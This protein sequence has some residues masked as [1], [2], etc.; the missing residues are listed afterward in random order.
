[1][2]SVCCANR[3]CQASNDLADMQCEA[4]QTPL[5]KR[6][7]WAVG[8]WINA[9]QPGE[10]LF[11]RYVLVESP[12]VLDM[13]PGL[14]V[15]G[16][17][18]VP[19]YIQPYQKLFPFRLNVPEVYDY[20]PS[21]DTELDL[22]VWLLHYG[23]I[24]LD[25]EGMPMYDHLLPSLSDRWEQVSPLQ[26][27]T[28]L[29]QIA[30]LWQPLL[31]YGV[32]SSLLNRD[33]LRVNGA[34]VHLQQ[35][36][37][38]DPQSY[39][40]SC[41][42]PVW[43]PLL[44]NAHPA[45]AEFCQV[46]WQRLKTGKIPHAE[47]LLTVL[48]TGIYAIAKQ[49]DITYQIFAATETV[50][51]RGQNEDACF[52]IGETAVTGQRLSNTLT[53]VCD[54]LGGQD[55]GEIASQ[56]VIE[57]LPTRLVSHVKKHMDRPKTVKRF[58]QAM[59]DDIGAVNNQ[60]SERNDHEAR[61]GRKRMGTTLVMFM[62]HFQ[63]FFLA[64]VGD[65]RCY[66]VTPQSCQQ[67]TVDDDVASR[68]VRMGWMLYR[69]AVESPRSGALTQAIGLWASSKLH[70]VIQRL[71][72]PCESIFLLCS[73]GLCDRQRVEQYWQ[74]MLQ[75][76]F[77]GD[78]TVEQ[79]T[80]ALIA[81]AN[82]KNGHDNVSVALIH[83]RVESSVLCLTQAETKQRAAEPVAQESE[84][85]ES[86]EENGIK[87]IIYPDMVSHKVTDFPVSDPT[88]FPIPQQNPRMTVPPHE[89]TERPKTPPASTPPLL[90]SRKGEAPRLPKTSV[91]VWHQFKTLSR[92]AQ[93][94]ILAGG[95]AFVSVLFFGIML[96]TR[97]NADHQTTPRSQR[98]LMERDV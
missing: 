63:Q 18:T 46:L 90:S 93:I 53:L 30:R 19:D 84:A 14:G 40:P 48:D 81:L 75:P 68:S 60:L 71:I 72:V 94:L 29:W 74:S 59:E 34:Q 20:L 25:D 65:S 33:W 4:C 56:W 54:G 62:A 58:M 5:I 67:V 66:W 78:R 39:E 32:V 43:E 28:W 50:P 13:R 3:E 61:T 76:I 1:M 42:A 6:Y 26:Q 73:V 57:H 87:A 96:A 89:S 49:F 9:F 23:A 97:K 52:P 10:L 77:D 15:E 12:I 91:R 47:H 37:I 36:K 82:E 41:L 17:E 95:V 70:P 44:T 92:F 8:D 80:T 86:D 16:P 24:A 35:L 21:S 38:D 45:I 51:S 27:L 98:L 11:D 64:N 55:G 79:A 31:Q 85:V 2:P 88:G 7:L 22:S 83:C 69:H